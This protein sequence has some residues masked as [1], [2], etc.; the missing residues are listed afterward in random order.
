MTYQQKP[1]KIFYS[2]CHKD[3]VYKND[4]HKHLAGLVENQKIEISHDKDVHAGAKLNKKLTDMI[5]ESDI[6]LCFMSD[7]YFASEFC[8]QEL[9]FSYKQKKIIIPIILSDCSWK[10]FKFHDDECLSATLALPLSPIENNLLPVSNWENRDKA[11]QSVHKKLSVVINAEYAIKNCQL[12][13]DFMGFLNDCEELNAFHSNKTKLHLGDIFVWPQ[14]NRTY[15]DDTIN[16]AQQKDLFSD[17]DKLGKIWITGEGRA[18]KTAVAKKIFLNLRRKG[19]VPVFFS[20]RYEGKFENQ[21]EKRISEQYIGLKINLRDTDKIIPIIDDFHH[22]YAQSK[23]IEQLKDNYPKHI[24]ITDKVFSFDFVNK[25]LSDVEVYYCQYKINPFYSSK[26]TELIEKWLNVKGS[27]QPKSDAYK[28]LDKRRALLDSTIGKT[29]NHGIIPWHPFYLL[30]IIAAYE[31]GN[32]QLA[33]ITSQ[34]H[35]YQALIYSNLRRHN[36]GHDD[37]DGYLNFL[38][39]LSYH[40]YEKGIYEISETDLEYFINKIYKEEYNLSVKTNT[41]ILELCTMGFL[42]KDCF[43]FYRFQHKY[44]YFYFVGK[45]IADNLKKTNKDI[46]HIFNNLH[47]DTNAYIAIFISHHSKD[48]VVLEN[49]WLNANLLFEKHQPATLNKKE[50]FF[51]DEKMKQIGNISFLANNKPNAARKEKSE[52]EDEQ[53]KKS[54]RDSDDYENNEE[55][56]QDSFSD[57]RKCIRT[58]EVM[59]QII[60]NRSDSLPKEKVAEI[61]EDAMNIYLRLLSFFIEV[62]KED[63]NIFEEHIAKAIEKDAKNRKQD[64]SKNEAKE[65]AQRIFSVMIFEIIVGC[66]SRIVFSLGAEKLSG[67]ISS[68]CDKINTPISILIKRWVL[69]E[70]KKHI[71][72]KEIN[73]ES[74]DFSVTAKRLRDFITVYHCHFHEVPFK[75]KQKISDI[76]KIPIASTRKKSD[77][78][79]IAKRK[80]DTKGKKR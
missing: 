28:E 46:E 64:L 61:F 21:L 36:L 9:G 32:T 80:F 4:M 41:L 15:Q 10:K 29:L 51:I 59:G 67:N 33:D 47:T 20:D 5:S 60:R 65:I 63:G 13:D 2:Y 68:V 71:N 27:E 14:F 79:V 69:M 76:L 26:R 78:N 62:L 22:H 57:I 56:N 16:N 30:A 48:D 72:I 35:C 7:N 23:L 38:Y 50:S 74:E 54:S 11:W 45:Y 77:Q 1:V 58:A 52:I 42:N 73:K 49:I 19:L 37:V 18:G 6:V 34:G 70:Y 53:E 40:F 24:L 12:N 25:Q 43:G 3:A 31:T 39:T 75:D 55:E 44:F 66:T 8:K 17:I